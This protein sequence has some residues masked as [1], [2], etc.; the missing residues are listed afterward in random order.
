MASPTGLFDSF[1]GQLP[2]EGEAPGVA[3]ASE[4]TARKAGR[5]QMDGGVLDGVMLPGLLEDGGQGPKHRR[6]RL[7]ECLRG[8]DDGVDGEAEI[9]VDILLGRA[10]AEAV[11]ADGGAA[12]GIVADPAF[13]A[14]GDAGF[15]G[16]PACVRRQDFL[17]VGRW[18]VRR[19]APSWAG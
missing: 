4:D 11:N 13:P 9:G 8:A 16:E 15:D 2:V 14:L 5:Q 19:R 3:H 10:G 17:L 12:G 6:L 18:T 7:Q 1:A